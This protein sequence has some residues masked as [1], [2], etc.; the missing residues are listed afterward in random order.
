M[1]NAFQYTIA[2]VGLLRHKLTCTGGIV[3]VSRSLIHSRL[4]HPHGC[5]QL[6]GVN[7]A[8][9]VRDLKR[10]HALILLLA[11]SQFPRVVAVIAARG[12]FFVVRHPDRRPVLPSNFL[13]AIPPAVGNIVRRGATV[14]SEQSQC[15][16]QIVV[17]GAAVAAPSIG[18]IQWP[19]SERK[20]LTVCC[21]LCHLVMLTRVTSQCS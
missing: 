20:Q 3:P 16:Y 15:L 10:A 6:R 11:A 8:R 18:E 4:P 13:P 5:R 19:A 14:E 12:V 9:L 21:P 1:Q 17:T 7:L 2:E